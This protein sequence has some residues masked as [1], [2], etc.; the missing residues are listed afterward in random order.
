MKKIL[1]AVVMTMTAA[2]VHAAPIVQTSDFIPDGERSHF[3]DFEHMPAGSSLP[4]TTSAD[5]IEV[6]QF[7]GSSIWTTCGLTCWQSN[8]TQ[9]WYPGGGDLGF[10]EIRKSDGSEFFD[11]GL[12]YGGAVFGIDV[13]SF[14]LLL[15]GASVLDGF[16]AMDPLVDGY[17]GFSGGGYDTV[18]VR[19]TFDVSSPGIITDGGFQALPIDNIEFRA[20]AIAVPEPG[21]MALLGLGLAGMG[22]V[23]RRRKIG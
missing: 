22:I 12:E 14:Q 17:V 10:T 7:G 16:V 23:A 13:L 4:A 18:R 8:P 1:T 21:T 11:V 15:D 5:G 6:E 9:S 19:G 3:V 20:A 2:S